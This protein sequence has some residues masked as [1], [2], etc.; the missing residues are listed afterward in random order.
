MILPIS[1]AYEQDFMALGI[2]NHWCCSLPAILSTDTKDTKKWW[3]PVHLLRH[4]CHHQQE[5]IRAR[6]VGKKRNN[7]Y[8]YH[9]YHT[10][11]NSTT[12]EENNRSTM[13]VQI[14]S[15]T[16]SLSSIYE[17]KA[18]LGKNHC[19][20]WC[21]VL[22]IDVIE[23]SHNYTSQLLINREMFQ[24]ILLHQVSRTSSSDEICPPAPHDAH[25]RT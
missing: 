22:H 25:S 7:Y 3:E 11:N 21:V 15:P 18:K 24:F 17:E 2:M 13:D 14:I 6:D 8:Y 5:G 9:R 12:L 16:G 23:S 1:I 20:C 19:R 4:R 10:A